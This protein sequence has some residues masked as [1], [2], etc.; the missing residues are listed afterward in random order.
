MLAR[1]VLL[2][3]LAISAASACAGS[4]APISSTTTA[5]KRAEAAP[6]PPDRAVSDSTG[7]TPLP[8][9][10][11]AHERI[12]YL[13]AGSVYLLDPRGGEPA[14]VTQRGAQAPDEAPALSPHGDAVAW[15]SRQ[16]GVSRLYV[17]APG[18]ATQRA[19]TDGKGGGDADPAWS[20]DGRK[21]AFVRGRAGERR[22]LYVL[23]FDA[24]DGGKTAYY[25]LRWVNPTGERGPWSEQAATTIAA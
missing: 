15:A 25:W 5:H 12:A 16:G 17:G 6:P 8:P 22:D 23:D 11:D 19:V 1:D 21:L 24:V 9:A 10:D 2:L 14:R 4:A 20:P 13:R 7:E 3:V 18:A